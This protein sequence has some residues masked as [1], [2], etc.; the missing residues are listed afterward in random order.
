MAAG[1]VEWE[2]CTDNP[3]RGK[4]SMSRIFEPGETNKKYKQNGQYYPE[5]PF[6]FIVSAD[7]YMGGK[8]QGRESDGAICVREKGLYKLYKL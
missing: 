2:D 7:T 4:F 8:A 3:E 5:N 1:I 6:L